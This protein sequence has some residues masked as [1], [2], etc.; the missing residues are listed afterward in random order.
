[1]KFDLDESGLIDIGELKEMLIAV[2]YEIPM[3]ELVVL[4]NEFDEDG[5]GA[6]DFEEFIQIF[7]KILGKDAQ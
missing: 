1:M 7:V 3:S 4:F 5:S 2:G 6:I